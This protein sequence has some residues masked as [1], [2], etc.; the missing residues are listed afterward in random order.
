MSISEEELVNLEIL[1]QEKSF[2]S[3]NPIVKEILNLAG[4][5][6]EKLR[7]YQNIE[8]T[9]RENVECLGSFEYSENFVGSETSIEAPMV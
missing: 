8:E 4:L 9:I 7:M 3:K 1:F 5:S 6:T 2:I